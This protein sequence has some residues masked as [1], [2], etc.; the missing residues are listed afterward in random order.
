MKNRK[1]KYQ[2]KAAHNQ[3]QDKTDKN[4]NNQWFGAGKLQK[5]IEELIL[6]N[7][8]EARTNARKARIEKTE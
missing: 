6:A 5:D 2:D 3:Y 8:D 7:Q 1:D 4:R